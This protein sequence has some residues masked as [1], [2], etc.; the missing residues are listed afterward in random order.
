MPGGWVSFGASSAVSASIAFTIT[1]MNR[2]S[3]MKVDSR[4]KTR[5]NAI[6]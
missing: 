6:A 4:M 1:P 2:L 5:K 3:A